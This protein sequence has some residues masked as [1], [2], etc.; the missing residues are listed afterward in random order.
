M[1]NPQ[2]EANMGN[3][4]S[5]IK[6]DT[7]KELVER[8]AGGDEQK[9]QE[10]ISKLEDM[11]KKQVKDELEKAKKEEFE[12]RRWFPERFI[13]RFSISLFFS[14]FF[15]FLISMF[16]LKFPIPLFFFYNTIFYLFFWIILAMFVAFLLGCKMQDP[17]LSGQFLAICIP[18]IF[19]SDVLFLGETLPRILFL[20]ALF[21]PEFLLPS[22]ISDK[23]SEYA[24]VLIEGYSQKSL[25]VP[26]SFNDLMK[27]ADIF[28]ML[29]FFRLD[30][31]DESNTR[32]LFSLIRRRSPSPYFFM[33]TS[34][35]PITIFVVAAGENCCEIHISSYRK[36]MN[37]IT[38][39]QGTERHVIF[40]EKLIKSSFKSIECSPNYEKEAKEYT[41]KRYSQK[42][43]LSFLYSKKVFYGL[44]FV[45]LGYLLIS[46]FPY[47]VGYF[48]S[49]PW[50]ATLIAVTISIAATRFIT[51][52]ELQE[53]RNAT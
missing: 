32:A 43:D 3:S 27:S 17:L 13:M 34:K 10:Y 23:T 20:L 7:L 48:D 49:H 22:I 47:I 29:G 46:R 31:G 25:C 50:A 36:K 45:I 5:E 38:R 42:K 18:L 16:Y 15:I 19:F 28:E 44:G 6:E 33:S 8:A 35:E 12:L 26:I 40:W 39:S 30:I 24:K 37:L 2:L 51:K 4:D 21:Y 41:F 14:I 9:K 53:A 11:I 1:S 52:K